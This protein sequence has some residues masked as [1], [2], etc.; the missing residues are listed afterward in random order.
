[1]FLDTIMNFQGRLGTPGGGLE[2]SHLPQTPQ[3]RKIST[4][5]AQF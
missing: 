5:T 2:T 1:M 4:A 3:G